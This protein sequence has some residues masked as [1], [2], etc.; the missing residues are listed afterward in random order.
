MNTKLITLGLLTLLLGACQS[1]NVPSD[2]KSA[3]SQ[4]QEHSKEA[5]EMTL[6]KDAFK[7]LGIKVG[8]LPQKALNNLVRAKGMLTVPP[9][10]KATVTSVLGANIS[11]I[12]V[13][14]GDPVEKGTVLAYLEH[15]NLMQLQSNYVKAWNEAQFLA[16]EYQRQQNLYKEKVGS[17]KELKQTQSAYQS[18]LAQAQSLESQLRMLH[19]NPQQLQEGK[20]YQRVPLKSPIAGFVQKV[21]V[22]TGQFIEPQSVI[23]EILDIHHLHV[24]LMVYEKDVHLIQIGQKVRVQLRAHPDSTYLAEIFAVGKNIEESPR[25]VHIHAELKSPKNY[26]VAGMYASGSIITDTNQVAALP[27]DALVQ[28]NEGFFAFTIEEEF[29]NEFHLKKVLVKAGEEIDGYRPIYNPEVF[30]NSERIVLNNAY[31]LFSD[32]AEG[33]GHHH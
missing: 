23:C 24:D 26:L 33:E 7:D 22:K 6:G 20:L 31:F 28:D 18:A 13:L 19:L 8:A 4:S 11:E 10:N 9:Q 27:A 1:E 21:N 32:M 29:E 16:N 14:E 5:Q 2:E 25:A 3:E 12:K 30:R 15:P 17:G